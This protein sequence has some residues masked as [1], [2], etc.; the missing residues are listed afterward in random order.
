MPVQGINE[1]SA[2]SDHE[3]CRSQTDFP[4]PSKH[5][6]VSTTVSQTGRGV[7]PKNAWAFVDEKWR[8]SAQHRHG[9]LAEGRES[10]EAAREFDDGPVVPAVGK[11]EER[12]KESMRAVTPPGFE[13]DKRTLDPARSAMQSARPML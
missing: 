12:L 1:G 13:F 6:A 4:Y 5:F 7:K 8:Y 11:L 3:Y 10:L 9:R 2:E